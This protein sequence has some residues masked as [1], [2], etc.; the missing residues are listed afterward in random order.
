MLNSQTAELGSPRIDGL[1]AP[2]D[3]AS[4]IGAAPFARLARQQQRPIA[5][6]GEEPLDLLHSVWLLIRRINRGSATLDNQF[7]RAAD[8]VGNLHAQA[9]L[10]EAFAIR[11]HFSWPALGDIPSSAVSLATSYAGFDAEAVFDL[12]DSKASAVAGC[13]GGNV[14]R[15]I[16]QP[17]ECRLFGTICTPRQPIGACM[18]TS[19]APCGAFWQALHRPNA[20]T[21]DGEQPA[22]ATTFAAGD[23]VIVSGTLGD[24]GVAMLS[25]REGIEFG[26]DVESNDANLRELTDAILHN[27]SWATVLGGRMPGGIAMTL[28]DAIA[29]SGLGI[30]LNDSSIV[31]DEQVE[32]ACELLNVDV[33]HLASAGRLIAI[34]SP[35]DAAAMLNAM[36]SVPAGLHAAAIGRVVEDPSQRVLLQ[37]SFGGSRVIGRLPVG[38]EALAA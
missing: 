37:G 25:C 13:Q 3:V 34:V 29:A 33:L 28:N 18:V 32:A 1:I 2:G 36:R 20:Q 5:V 15:G 11:E 31:Q 30:I 26:T 19:D 22:A 27:S 12:P 14:L 35:D 7:V 38:A 4:V 21:A 16:S 9:L 8:L 17:S 10:S 23:L 6:S 24:D